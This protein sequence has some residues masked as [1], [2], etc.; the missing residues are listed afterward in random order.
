MGVNTADSN[1][2]TAEKTGGEKTHTLTVSEIPSHAH[3]VFDI[4]VYGQGV[5][6]FNFTT[7][8]TGDWKGTLTDT[9]A[10]GGGQAHNNLPPYIICYIWKRTA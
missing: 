10:T 1:F 4:T 7:D 3:T 2:N 9:E 6:G 5:T 8:S